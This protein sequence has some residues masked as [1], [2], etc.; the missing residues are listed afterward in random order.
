MTSWK[1]IRMNVLRTKTGFYLSLIV[2]YCVNCVLAYNLMSLEFGREGIGFNFFTLGILIGGGFLMYLE[3]YVFFLILDFLGNPIAP[4]ALYSLGIISGRIFDHDPE[5]L[6]LLAKKYNER[7]IGKYADWGK[8]DYTAVPEEIE[9]YKLR[10]QKNIEREQKRELKIQADNEQVRRM[11]R[12]FG[13]AYLIILFIIVFVFA[14]GIALE[15][16]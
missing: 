14:L 15:K 6:E 13:R 12:S 16:L 10:K 5:E 4:Y 3:F 9:A 7:R 8:W 1:E 11:M 2:I